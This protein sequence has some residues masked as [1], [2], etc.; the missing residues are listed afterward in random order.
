M[1]YPKCLE[2]GKPRTYRDNKI[3]R[4]KECHVKWNVGENNPSWKGS[5]EYRKCFLCGKARKYN[6]GSKDTRRCLECYRKH[7]SKQMAEKH[8]NWKGG[9][10]QWKCKDCGGKK[11]NFNGKRC[12]ACYRKFWR[13]ENH[14]AYKERKKNY[15][16][17]I[18]KSIDGKRIFEHRFVM[19]KYLGRKL[20]ESEIVHHLNGIRNDNRIE[21]LEVTT[22][23]HHEPQTYIKIL[24]KRIRELEEELKSKP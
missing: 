16:G 20:K 15:S 3:R 14:P 2:C 7:L 10:K 19:E 24:Q 13:G 1:E 23:Q 8:P 5:D 22:R 11:F 21:N 4:C 12:N 6:R 18:Y 9:K 17:Y